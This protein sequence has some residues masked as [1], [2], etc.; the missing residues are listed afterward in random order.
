MRRVDAT[1]VRKGGSGNDFNRTVTGTVY[2]PVTHVSVNWPWLTPPALLVLLTCVCLL[3]TM[4]QNKRRGYEVWKSSS[5]VALQ[6]LGMDARQELCGSGGL[7]K[8]S[9]LDGQAEQMHVCLEREEG[10]TLK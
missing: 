8:V 6:A 5:I 2:I 10:W 3:V 4:Y 7:K 1:S 9:E